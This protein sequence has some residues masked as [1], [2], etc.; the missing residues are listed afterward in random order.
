V[1]KRV[2][3]NIPN[4]NEALPGLPSDIVVEVPTQVSGEK[5]V[6]EPLERIPKRIYLKDLSGL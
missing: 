6:P 1:E 3:L 5:I 4:A 2:M